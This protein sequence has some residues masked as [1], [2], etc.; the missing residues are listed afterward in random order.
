MKKLCLAIALCLPSL[1]SAQ[2]LQWQ[3]QQRNAV[4]TNANATYSVFVPVGG[5]VA[6]R[7]TSGTVTVVSAYDQSSG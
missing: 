3:A 4:N 6:V 7:Q 2:A 1:A 5:Y